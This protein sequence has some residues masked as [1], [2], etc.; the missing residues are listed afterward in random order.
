MCFQAILLS[1]RYNGDGHKNLLNIQ[2]VVPFSLS[3]D[4]DLISRTIIPV[5]QQ[6]DVQP[7]R[8]Q[9]GLGD[10][11]QSFWFSPKEPTS[12]GLVWGV[13]AVGLLPTGT[14]GI[15]ADTWGFGPTIVALKQEGS[16]T[17]GF[18]WNQIWDTGG[19]ADISSMFI[20]PFLAKG[21]GN[22]RTLSINSESTY[23]WISNKW[24]VPINI[25]Y[26]KVSKW[27]TQMVSN[28][29]GVGIYV[30]TPSG[31]PD[32]QLRYTLTLLFPKG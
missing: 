26:S 12:S 11:T 8:S 1:L 19:R 9:F 30:T 10:T 22:G 4:W 16:W 15:G 32:W 18:L 2:P 3:E 13:G 17:Y 20:Q 31:G 21:L 7:G 29:V 23:N 14:D 27:G 24:S 6:N 25:A 5:I 28:Q